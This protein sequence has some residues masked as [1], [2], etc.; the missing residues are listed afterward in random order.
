LIEWDD[1][2][3]A[4]E[5]LLSESTRAREVEASALAETRTTANGASTVSSAGLR[6]SPPPK[7]AHLARTQSRFFSL[8]TQPDPLE[9]AAARLPGDPEAAPIDR[10]ISTPRSGSA[11]ER[12]GVYAQMYFH[13]LLDAAKE[14]Y[15]RLL[16]LVGDDRFAEIFADFLAANPPES[17][18]IKYVARRL[19][20]LLDTLDARPDLGDLAR[21]EWARFDVRDERDATPLTIQDLSRMPADCLGELSLRLA[22]YVKLVTLRNEVS[23]LWSSLRDGD[24]TPLPRASVNSMLIWRRSFVVLHRGVADDEATA[25][26]LVQQGATLTALCEQAA[27][28]GEPLDAASAR[29]FG[30]IQQWIADEILARPPRLPP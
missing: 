26:A 22:P 24:A 5:V 9:D 30:M 14:T 19:P 8:I 21:L 13:R 15:P 6:E 27:R 1:E 25:L 4:Y 20:A 17:A 3:P 28:P 18:S 23:E 12:L 7:V 10:W 11:S 2:I 16:S 29:I